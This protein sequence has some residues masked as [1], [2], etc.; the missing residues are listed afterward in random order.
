MVRYILEQR[1]FLYD[2]YV[3]CGSARNCGRKFPDERVASRRTIHNLMNKLRTRGLLIVK[4]EKHKRRVLTEKLVDIGARL[5]H[6]PRKSQK[7]LAQ[8]TEVSKS[9]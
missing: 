1:V 8:E 4:K 9:S 3:K 2:A 5:E 7:N 6:T